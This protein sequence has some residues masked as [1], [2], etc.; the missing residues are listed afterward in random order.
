MRFLDLTTP[1]NLEKYK[2]FDEAQWSSVNIE[3]D[4][5]YELTMFIVASL[6]ALSI[7]A[8]FNDEP[9]PETHEL[10]K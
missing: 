6:Y 9:K 10:L 2:N 4:Y 5:V 8:K 3:I 1:K 7:E